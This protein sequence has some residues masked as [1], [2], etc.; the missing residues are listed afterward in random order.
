MKDASYSHLDTYFALQYTTEDTPL[1]ELLTL[2]F[3]SFRKGALSLDVSSHTHLEQAYRD[4]QKNMPSSLCSHTSFL[5]LKRNWD[6]E[7]AILADVKRL[8]NRVLPPPPLPVPLSNLYPEQKKAVE[9]VLSH[10]F[11]IIQGGPGTGKTFLLSF[12][13]KG[14]DTDRVLFLAPTGKAVARLKKSCRSPAKTIHAALGLNSSFSPS[15]SSIEADLLVVDESSMIDAELLQLLLH[16]IRGNTRVVMVGDALQLPPVAGPGLFSSLISILPTTKLQ[17]SVRTPSSQMQN[18][19]SSLLKGKWEGD[20]FSLFPLKEIAQI[21]AHISSLDQGFR[22]L[23]ALGILSC[24][25]EGIWGVEEMNKQIFE[26]VGKIAQKK[27]CSTYFAPII[28]QQNQER[29]NL[30]NGD[31][32]IMEYQE[33]KPKRAY[34]YAGEE[35]L[36]SLP[37]AD[38]GFYSLAFC[39]SVHKSQGS[40]F[41]EVLLLLPP[42][43]EK[44]GKEVVYTGITRAKKKITVYG[45]VDTMEKTLQYSTP[46]Y[47]GLQKRW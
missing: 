7:T 17:H 25:N 22:Q 9:Q 11:S 38:L 29:K 1:F 30:F 18:L 4:L 6:L 37:P 39:I 45:S 24:L 36:L 28:I 26:E 35:S 34:F 46:F 14:W 41:E 10:P 8:Y 5:Y 12:L 43:S 15:V 3:A 27:N 13:E 47:K 44:L 31:M 42:G 19:F 16:T 33:G 21:Y 23:Q 2:L 32:G 40:E 20:L